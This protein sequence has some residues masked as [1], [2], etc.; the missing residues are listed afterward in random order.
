MTSKLGHIYFNTADANRALD[1]YVE[2]FGSGSEDVF[3]MVIVWRLFSPEKEA[4]FAA[5]IRKAI[6]TGTP[7][8]WEETQDMYGLVCE[9]LLI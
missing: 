4:D 5:I 9:D 6:R 7:K 8:T 1:E 2:A 3:L